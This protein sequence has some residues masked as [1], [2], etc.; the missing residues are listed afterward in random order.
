MLAYLEGNLGHLRAMLAHFGAM[1]AHL[2]PILGLGWPILGLCWPSCGLCWPMLT[3]L[4]PQE[5]KNGN[6]KK[7]RKTRDFF[8]TF[9]WY[10]IHAR[11]CRNFTDS[12]LQEF[13]SRSQVFFLTSPQNF[14]CKSMPQL[15]SLPSPRLLVLESKSFS[16]PSP[17]KPYMQEYASTSQLHLS[18]PSCH[19]SKSFL[20]PP[21][22]KP[23]MQEYAS[24]SQLHLSKTSCHDSKSFSK[25]SPPKP[26]MQE[27]A[28]NPQLHLSKTSC[29]DSK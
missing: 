24:T 17:P 7:H 25:P 2:G 21:P 4:G 10:A 3:H 12:P 14:A 6:S 26:Y 13:W 18:K 8:D 5:S 16:K 20:K 22:P 15:Q 29:H 9:W 19:E 11:V 1:L 28:S 27:Y 23:Y